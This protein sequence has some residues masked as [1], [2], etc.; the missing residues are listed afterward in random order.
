MS[1]LRDIWTDLVDKRLWPVAAALLVA[2][3]A[4]PV[5]LTKPATAPKPAPAPMAD[6]GPA[7][8]VSDPAAIAT[9]RPGGPVTGKAKN[10]FAQ[11]HVREAKSTS[12]GADGPGTLSSSSSSSDTVSVAPSGGGGSALT[13][14]PQPPASRPDT[15][16][17]KRLKVRF[18]KTDGK[19][20]V[21]LLAPGT[22][23]P[24]R[25]N[26]V[27]VFV[28]F[29]RGDRAELLVSSDA[30][31]QGDGRC[32]PSRSICSQ[33][34]VKPGHTLFFDVTRSSGDVQYQLDVLGVVE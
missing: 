25:A 30:A 22:P 8:L 13:T 7:A 24:S 17:G 5:V 9:A 33:L 2:L 31:P 11:Q 20:R 15:E 29:V 1:F 6:V 27:F 16:D 14:V 18:G 26:P 3:V 12:A 21:R 28:D 10:P 32:E 34:F 19:S 23:L 4:I